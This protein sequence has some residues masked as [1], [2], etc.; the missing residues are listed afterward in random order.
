M[1]DIHA[2]FYVGRKVELED[3]EWMITACDYIFQK[4]HLRQVA[5]LQHE[6]PRQHCVG[7]HG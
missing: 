2:R 7:S 4:A 5:A 3:S 1:S 6:D